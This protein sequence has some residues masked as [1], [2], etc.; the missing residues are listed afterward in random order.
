MYVFKAKATILSTGAAGFR[1]YGWPIN[2]LTG[3]EMAMAYR[4][5]VEML[6]TEFLDTHS[7]S[8]DYPADGLYLGA[9][10]KKERRGDYLMQ[11]VKHSLS[12]LRDRTH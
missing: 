6:E 4:A 8:A 3:D 7:T 2:N 1:P 9:R 5:G 10:G 12:T 11:K